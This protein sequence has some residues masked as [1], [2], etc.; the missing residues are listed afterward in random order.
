MEITLGQVVSALLQLALLLATWGVSTIVR[1]AG[2]KIDD[3]TD[4]VREMGRKLEAQGQELARGDQ[5]FRDL[6]RRVD[7]L[8]RERER[9]RGVRAA[10][11][12]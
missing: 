11:G 7:V 12:P 6:E 10:E 9:F 5:R 8:E 3:L 4:A 1:G 2:R